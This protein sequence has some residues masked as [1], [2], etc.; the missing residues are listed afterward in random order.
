MRHGWTAR[1]DTCTKCT[2]EGLKVKGW[3]G[4]AFWTAGH[5]IADACG[6]CDSCQAGEP[7]ICDNGRQPDAGRLIVVMVG[8]DTPHEID[9]DDAEPVAREGFC[10]ECGQLGCGHDGL[11]REEVPTEA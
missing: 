9:A 8:D 3:A 6:E 10:G 2:A 11:S 5:P 1:R 4:V 7:E